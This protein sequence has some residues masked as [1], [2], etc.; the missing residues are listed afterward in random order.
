M[1]RT[2]THAPR[3]MGLLFA[4]A[5]CLAAGCASQGERESAGAKAQPATPL[6]APTSTDPV[7]ADMVA[8][9]RR[10]S[11]GGTLEVRV[12]VRL[13]PGHH[14]YGRDAAAAWPYSPTRLSLTLPLGISAVGEWD[15]PPPAQT[16]GG[17]PVYTGAVVFRCRLRVGPEIPLGPATLAGE[18][19]FQVCNAEACWPPDAL[20]IS[21][22]ILI[23]RQNP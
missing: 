18:I 17:E 16:R 22:S 6:P 12:L 2:P 13:K 9:P 1:N 10:V 15:C 20:P 7:A 21:A 8:E 5:L 4:A 19:Q 3:T 14:I 11:A 23:Q